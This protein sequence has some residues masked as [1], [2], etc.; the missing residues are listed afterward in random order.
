MNN[1]II[2]MISYWILIIFQFIAL[3]LIVRYF[4]QERKDMREVTKDL[5]HRLM[6]KNFQDYS[7]GMHIQ[8]KA[9]TDA[10]MVEKLY[11]ITEED[12]I[13]SDRLPVT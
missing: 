1:L 9:L 7:A 6:A 2:L 12:K 13:K 11:D 10:E 5:L 8:N 4:T 3:F